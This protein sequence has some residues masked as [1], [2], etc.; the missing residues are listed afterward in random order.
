M[1]SLGLLLQHFFFFF[2]GFSINIAIQDH[3]LVAVCVAICIFWF[4]NSGQ[5]NSQ[6]RCWL[7]GFN[8]PQAVHTHMDMV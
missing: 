5:K 4:K 6:A 1:A 3:P 8:L 7:K 2:F